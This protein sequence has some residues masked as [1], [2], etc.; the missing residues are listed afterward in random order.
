MH[1]LLGIGFGRFPLEMLYENKKEV[2][3]PIAELKGKS[4]HTSE[5]RNIT[6]VN[7]LYNIGTTSNHSIH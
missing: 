4:A 6:T 1:F 5:N 2:A 7:N 3:Q